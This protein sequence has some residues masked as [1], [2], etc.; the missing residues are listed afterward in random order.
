MARSKASCGRLRV[1]GLRRIPLGAE[2]LE[3]RQLLAT[4]TVNSS[5]DADG[6]DG[7]STL[8][9]RQAIEVANGT[10]AASS[11]T[12]SQQAQVSGA[13]ETPNT[14]DFNISGTGPFTIEPT[15]ALP[16]ITAS[17]V[18]DGY[19][20]PGA[21][22]NTNG[23]GLGDNAIIEVVLNGSLLTIP[24]NAT[25]PVN[26]YQNSGLV[27]TGGNSTVQ[28]LE[29]DRFDGEFNSGGPGSPRPP[30]GPISTLLGGAIVLDGGGGYTIRGNFLGTDA[31]GS[32]NLGSASGVFDKD[33][34]AHS[35]D[36][37]GGPSPAD[38]NVISGDEVGVASESTAAIQGNFIGTDPSGTKAVPNLYQAIFSAAN[39]FN[40][41][42]GGNVIVGNLISGNTTATAIDG[43]GLI[44][45]NLIGTDVTGTKALGNYEGYDAYV[46]QFNNLFPAR[47]VTI[48]GTSASDRNVI[49]AST[50]GGIYAQNQ[51]N[52]SGV[53]ETFLIQG[54]YIGTDLTGTIALGNG[55]SGIVINAS[56][57][58]TIGGTAAGAGNVISG[59]AADGIL[60]DGTAS[61]ELIQGNLIGV[62]ASGTKALPNAG[63]GI[64][65]SGSSSTIGGTAAGARNVISGNSLNGLFIVTRV[66][67]VT[68]LFG[69]VSYVLNPAAGNLVQ[70]NFI[71]TDATGTQALGNGLD[72]VLV[73][74][75]SNTIGGTVAESGLPVTSNPAANVIRS[76]GKSGVGVVVATFD[77]ADPN[78][79][80]SAV[81]Q[82]ISG[83]GQDD[84]ILGNSI[85]GN[86]GLGIDLGD[87]GVNA[88][89]P[90]GSPT[91]PNRLQP[92]P[93]IVN[94]V[95]PTLDILTGTEVTGAS[96]SLVAAPSTAYTI[97]F[98]ASQPSAD[99]SGQGQTYLGSQSVTTDANGVGGTTFIIPASAAG[100][101]LSMTATDPAGNTSEFTPPSATPPNGLPIPLV[102]VAASATTVAQGQPITLTAAVGSMPAG[103]PTGLVGFVVDGAV[104]GFAPINAQGLA[105]LTLPTSQIA[106]GAGHTVTAA[107]QGDAKFAP[108]FSG[109]ALQI[110]VTTPT[111]ST[112]LIAGSATTAT[113]GQPITFAA[114][115]GPGATGLV[116]FVANGSQVLGYAPLDGSGNA[117]FVTDQ[118]V[119]GQGIIPGGYSITAVYLGDASR[120]PGISVGF[121]LQ[122]VAG[123][124]T[125]GPS[126][127][128]TAAVGTKAVTVSFD[129]ALLLGPAQD[130]AN[131][132][133]AAPGGGTINVTSATYDPSNRTVTLATTQAL[134]PKLTYKLTVKGVRVG[135]IQDVFG[136][137][138]NAK[139]PGRAGSN[140]VANFKG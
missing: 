130:L 28:G 25:A 11:L 127:T 27:L 110:T 99:G 114:V 117:T 69:L 90:A 49:S 21:S 79:P 80:G 53:P 1:R 50:F 3:G 2:I 139:S 45:G 82:P 16:I 34:A 136:L 68:G 31:T 76:N 97:E 30:P 126:V 24:P 105:T 22:P 15:T 120:P 46:G 43:G 115:V 116:A 129:Q 95:G 12:A 17:V 103:Q 125:K 135:G 5:G 98:F 20:Q 85:Y 65:F 92:Y 100:M 112:V 38:R 102:A 86:G 89:N 13:L 104:V 40:E 48:G 64:E 113:Q 70:G 61:K 47:N 55:N 118:L 94:F 96:V 137:A 37:I 56:A 132:A 41:G 60:A 59:N 87:D 101:A 131:Y 106:V 111:S 108:A 39:D 124:A 73:E 44:Q 134:N 88:N 66:I 119:P 138:L 8:S 32:L 93:V 107:Y 128:R 23:P 36:L 57:T 133:L 52:S 75:S 109:S 18:I 67:K 81:G 35:G 19:S 71:G 4:I 63:N 83:S 33:L 123:Q 140:T 42:D 9:L 77:V 72:G 54:N 84:A 58:A 7:G 78:I 26:T 121:L 51:A 62:D 74:G 6:A 91:G 122:I 29:V 14:I 10:L